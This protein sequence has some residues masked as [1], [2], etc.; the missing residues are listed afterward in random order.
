M[1]IKE[2][3][4]GSNS[5]RS[6][7]SLRDLD[8]QTWQLVA[9]KPFDDQQQ[10][11]LRVVGYPGTLRIN[12]PTDLEIS[13]GRKNWQL[14]DITM[15]NNAL[16]QD[17]RQAAAEFDLTPLIADLKNDRPLRFELEG[18]FTELPI[19]PYLVSEWRSLI[20]D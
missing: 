13:S 6:L 2:F 19:P 18:V 14:A 11:V 20:D 3:E 7:E 8:Y 12:H 1:Q 17:S 5:V 4:D 10:V 9:Y 16:A 15:S